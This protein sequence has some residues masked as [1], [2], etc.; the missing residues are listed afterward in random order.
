[1]VKI[2]ASVENTVQNLFIEIQPAN[3]NPMENVLTCDRGNKDI[4]FATS[5]ETTC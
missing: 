4:T 2:V 1:M 3:C 5:M